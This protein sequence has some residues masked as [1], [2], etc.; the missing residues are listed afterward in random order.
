MN[1]RPH[2][3]KAHILAHLSAGGTL[4]DMKALK[5]FGCWSL[6]QRISEMR[7]DGIPIL[8]KMVTAKSGKRHAIYWLELK[9][10]ARLQAC[11]ACHPDTIPST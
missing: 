4:D 5:L 9:D 11:H 8:S 7:A 3:Y 2:T 6:S 10:K 1:Y